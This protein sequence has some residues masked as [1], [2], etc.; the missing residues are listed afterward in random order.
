MRK[1]TGV[2]TAVRRVKS[3]AGW[4][5]IYGK[6]GAWSRTVDIIRTTPADALADARREVAGILES[7]SMQED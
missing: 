7:W 5:G 4:K 3:P 6:R 2:Y 1:T